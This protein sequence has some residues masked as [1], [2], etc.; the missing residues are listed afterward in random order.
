MLINYVYILNYP[1]ALYMSV[2]FSII[3][4]CSGAL[5][6]AGCHS[7]SSAQLLFPSQRQNGGSRGRTC[8]S[9]RGLRPFIVLA[10][11]SSRVG[12][13]PSPSPFNSHSRKNRE[14]F[15]LYSFWIWPEIR[16]AVTVVDLAPAFRCL[17][18]SCEGREWTGDFGAIRSGAISVVGRIQSK[19]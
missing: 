16:R 8:A 4:P 17:E 9:R 13:S 3:S 10:S 14:R 18:G 5:S 6:M 1:L 19:G 12:E 11:R 2:P 15:Y 7:L